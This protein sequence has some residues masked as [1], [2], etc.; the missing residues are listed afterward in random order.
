[1]KTI[2][3]LETG[4]MIERE[5]NSEELAQQAI[6]EAKY[7][8]QQ[9]IKQA[10]EDAKAAAKSSAEAKLSALGLTPEEIAALR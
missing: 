3:N 1:M 8:E 6:D 2:H 4:E 7:Q 5:L 10:E 9:A